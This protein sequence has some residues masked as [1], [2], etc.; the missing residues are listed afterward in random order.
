MPIIR[1]E[2]QFFV[3]GCIFEDIRFGIHR[4]HILLG[5]VQS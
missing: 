5:V 1:L 2:Q 4:Y 3:V